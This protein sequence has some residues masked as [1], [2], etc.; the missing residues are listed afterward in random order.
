MAKKFLFGLGVG[1]LGCSVYPMFKNKLRS[2]TVNML[3]GAITAG[4]TTKSFMEEVNEKAM[5]HRENRFK[6]VSESLESNP[7]N[8]NDENSKNIALL[9]KQV[10]ELKN[11][12]QEM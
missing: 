5:E 8:E 9:K 7:L 6:R 11:K 12:I 3:E 10:E 2:M 4:T 1:V